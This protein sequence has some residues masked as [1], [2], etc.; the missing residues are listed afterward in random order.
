MCRRF[1]GN[2]ATRKSRCAPRAAAADSGLTP[3]GYYPPPHSERKPK[4]N[5]RAKFPNAT[6]ADLYDPLSM[7]AELSKA[8]AELDRAVDQCYRGQKFDSDRERVE[9]LFRLYEKLATPLTARTDKKR[10]KKADPRG[11]HYSRT[12][13]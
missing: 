1:S 12:M 13:T 4:L 2:H 9:F 6:L 8:H 10:R 3:L 7:P 5:A 11:A